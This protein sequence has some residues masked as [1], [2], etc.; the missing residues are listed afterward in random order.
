MKIT[1]ISA[2]ELSDD[3]VEIWGR[4]QCTNADL[5]SPYFH[6]RFTSVIASV[7][8][9]VE[10]AIAESD[11]RIVAFFP[12][13]RE[14]GV[15]GQPVGGCISDYQG[16]ICARDFELSPGELLKHTQLAS[17]HFDHL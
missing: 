13:Q 8:D 7:R 3:L 17:W 12:F 11:R 16:L 9:D 10:V 2:R 14:R 1:L 6:P 4:L 15:V 5:D